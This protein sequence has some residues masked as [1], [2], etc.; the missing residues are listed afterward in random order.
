MPFDRR[1]AVSVTEGM[2]HGRS[3]IKGLPGGVIHEARAGPSTDGL[4]GAL[5]LPWAFRG[6]KAGNVSHRANYWHAPR[7]VQRHVKDECLL[8]LGT[9]EPNGPEELQGGA[10]PR[11]WAFRGQESV[12]TKSACMWSADV[13]H[14][15]I[16]HHGYRAS[17]SQEPVRRLP[18][19]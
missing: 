11:A 8:P 7:P 5:P 15:R 4:S 13:L 10:L 14:R 17:R 1:M 18:G 2:G 3:G 6:Q 12:E 9:D 16:L 19:L